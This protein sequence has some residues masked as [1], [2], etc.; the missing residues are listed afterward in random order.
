MSKRGPTGRLEGIPQEKREANPIEMKL[1]QTI[2]DAKRQCGPSGLKE[3]EVE[4]R[5]GQ[6]TR[7]G[8]RPGV[9]E[10]T[11]ELIRRCLNTKPFLEPQ[12]ESSELVFIPNN[13]KTRYICDPISKCLQRI[14][15][16]ERLGQH[17]NDN[18]VKWFGH[19]V[20]FSLARDVDLSHEEVVRS[21]ERCGGGS[22][23]VFDITRFLEHEDS[24]Y[25]KRLKRRLTFF[26]KDKTL[27]VDLTKV[28]SSNKFR[29]EGITYEVE[30]ELTTYALENPERIDKAMIFELINMFDL[31]MRVANDPHWFG[32]IIRTKLDERNEMHKKGIEIAYDIVRNTF[33]GGYGGKKPKFPGSM[34]INFRAR[35]INDVIKKGG[36]F[37]SEKTDGERY[38]L[39]IKRGGWAYLINRPMDVFALEKNFSAYLSAV[40]ASGGDT[41]LDIELVRHLNT[42]RP[43]FM[44]FDVML[45]NGSNGIKDRTLGE[46]LGEIGRL[47]GLHRKELKRCNIPIPV[48]VIGK[49]FL[50]VKNISVF[51]ELITHIDGIDPHGSEPR[52]VYDDHTRRCHFSDGLI[53]APDTPYYPGTDARLI[54]W[55]YP[56]YCTID[57]AFS[58]NN[59]ILSRGR[60]GGEWVE[61]DVF[62]AT[63]SGGS[64]VDVKFG[65]GFVKPSMVAGCL[66]DRK[67]IGEFYYDRRNG[68]WYLCGDRSSEKDY[69]NGNIVAVDIL[70]SLAE[71]VTFDELEYRILSGDDGS[72]WMRKM[73]ESKLGAVQELL[74]SLRK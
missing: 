47:I 9:S 5:I 63:W 72:V 14:N 52:R 46:R 6:V 2:D 4:L 42:L 3:I 64:R 23:A 68:G 61:V 24:P 69:P 18:C 67:M 74:A 65:S 59:D 38:L 50:P 44:V 26:S 60:C 13:K 62:T 56:A 55:K 21:Q 25:E 34:P 48:D 39:A 33:Q 30:I 54:K 19:Y 40:F 15:Y 53:F 41:L 70:A 57:F 37:V 11:F 12:V 58:V 31:A 35:H 51:R 45:T 66:P 17:G 8:F 28:E 49:A 73:E 1:A 32:D 29:I 20:R 36:Y 43:V 22:N 7:E 27:K 71:N 10:G 16:K